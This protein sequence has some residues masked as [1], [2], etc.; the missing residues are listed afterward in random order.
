MGVRRGFERAMQVLL[1]GVGV[2]IVWAAM[3]LTGW[4]RQRSPLGA[5]PGYLDAVAPLTY[6]AGALLVSVSATL[7]IQMAAAARKRRVESPRIPPTVT[8]DGPPTPF[9]PLD[10]MAESIAR[11]RSWADL[12][13]VPPMAGSEA[14]P[15]EIA[16]R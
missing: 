15:G 10:P 12:P 11:G 13:A 9:R 8:T 1:W 7:L 16:A 2:T 5:G 4:G 6:V 3:A 14:A